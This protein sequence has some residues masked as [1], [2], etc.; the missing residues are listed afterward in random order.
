MATTLDSVQPR[1][2]IAIDCRDVDLLARFWTRL[3]G[4]GEVEPMDEVYLAVKDSSGAGPRIVF[5]KV[6]DES[7]VKSPIH[8][9]LHVDDPTRWRQTVLDLGGTVLDDHLI[10]EAGSRW[11][12]CLDP[13]GNV[14]CLVQ[15][16]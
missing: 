3:L 11:L 15:E 1:V 10:E 6:Q 2:E 14:F 13:E 12:R 4:Y 8:L 7:V 5:Q 9:D 16:R